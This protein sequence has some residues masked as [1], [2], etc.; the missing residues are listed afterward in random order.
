[1]IHYIR[2]LGAANHY[3]GSPCDAA[4]PFPPSAG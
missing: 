2:A 1:M 4:M 3:C